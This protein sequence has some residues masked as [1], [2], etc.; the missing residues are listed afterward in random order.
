MKI[1]EAIEIAKS[2]GYA[3]CIQTH[4]MRRT[5]KRETWLRICT[6]TES[7]FNVDRRWSRDALLTYDDITRD[8]WVEKGDE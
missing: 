3:I 5:P 4:E 6:N 1:S 8:D 7:I 2:R